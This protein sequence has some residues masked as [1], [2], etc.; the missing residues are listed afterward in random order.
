[1]GARLKSQRF[2]ALVGVGGIG[3]GICFALEGDHTLGRNESRPGRL[4]D[5]R[6]YCKL[7]IIAHYVARLMGAAPG[8]DPFHVAPVGLVGDDEPGRRMIA[9]MAAA[10]MDTT[11]VKTARGRP[12]LFSVCFQYPDGSGGNITTSNAAAGALTAADVEAAA[13]IFDANPGAAVALA[14]P[15]AP[16]AGRAALLEIAAARDSLCVLAVTSAEASAAVDAGLFAKAD[17]A[18]LNEDE[19]AVLAGGEFNPAEPRPFLDSLAS[20]LRRGNEGIRIIFSAGKAGAWGFEDGRW[21]FTAPPEVPVA[22][23]AGAGDALLAGAIA[24]IATGLPLAAGRERGSSLTGR[25]VETALDFA[26]LLAAFTVTSPHTIHP[27]ADLDALVEFAGEY[28]IRFSCN[29]TDAFVTDRG[30]GNGR[31]RSAC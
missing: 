17:L 5:V 23:T 29:L 15:E 27:D 30:A 18:A 3:T 24:G 25:T 14:A 4:L 9:Q 19:A 2:K 13:P 26:V 12:T 16:L 11:H 8:G 10:G 6:D 1:M 20:A 28:N 21:D 7:H 22:G 31:K